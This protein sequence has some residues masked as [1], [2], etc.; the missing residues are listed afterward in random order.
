MD[1]RE[2]EGWFSV[3]STMKHQ[4]V[5]PLQ[6]LDRFASTAI[7]QERMRLSLLIYSSIN[8]AHRM[9]LIDRSRSVYW[10]ESASDIRGPLSVSLAASTSRQILPVYATQ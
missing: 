5:K 3:Q 8:V 7:F 9:R 2:E 10:S 6:A 4:S 1:V